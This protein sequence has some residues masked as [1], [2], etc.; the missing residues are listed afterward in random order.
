MT[1]TG[2]GRLSKWKRIETIYTFCI[3][4]GK[5]R[6]YIAG[7]YDVKTR[8]RRYHIEI[9]VPKHVRDMVQLN[10]ILLGTPESCQWAWDINNQSTYPA[11]VIITEDG[12]VR[13]EC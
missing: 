5:K 11:L 1:V 3:M 4:P 13:E 8:L 10:Q 12:K 7:P 9:N 6:R 2:Y